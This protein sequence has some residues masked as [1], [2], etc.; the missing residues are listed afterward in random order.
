MT[1]MNC[2]FHLP[3]IMCSIKM[4]K[5]EHYLFDDNRLISGFK[6]VTKI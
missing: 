2:T 3:K 6:A 5:A 1:L 4:I